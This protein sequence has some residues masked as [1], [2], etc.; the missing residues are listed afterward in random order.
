MATA[1]KRTKISNLSVKTV[2]KWI[3]EVDA[4]KC[5]LR[6]TADNDSVKTINCIVCSQFE[7]R[8]K[9]MH[10]FNRAFIDGL[11]GDRMK[12]DTVIKHSLSSM[13]RQ[14]TV[15]KLAPTTTLEDIMK[16]TPIGMY[17]LLFIV[18]PLPTPTHYSAFYPTTLLRGWNGMVFVVSGK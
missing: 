5:W 3:F 16:K 11:T 17:A 14:A 12:K 7:N 1:A 6:F 13:H 2:E 18:L 10:N 15:L 4:T 9:H 8:L